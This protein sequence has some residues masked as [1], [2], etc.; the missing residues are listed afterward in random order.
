MARTIYPEVKRNGQL[1]PSLFDLSPSGV[2]HAEVVTNFA[3]SSYLAFSPLPE[4]QAV[5]FLW[6][7]PRI[8]SGGRYPPLCPAV[9]GLSSLTKS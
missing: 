3:V 7:F 1:L 2:Y 8:A 4:I 6:H 9:A 5:Y